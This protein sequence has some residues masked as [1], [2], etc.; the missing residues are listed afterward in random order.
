MC[1]FEFAEKRKTKNMK[2]TKK[3][4]TVSSFSMTIFILNKTKKRK[5]TIVSSESDSSFPFMGYNLEEM[6]IH[7]LEYDSSIATNS[8]KIRAAMPFPKLHQGS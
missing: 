7:F 5:K 2:Q 8:F 3:S 6:L 4:N 1:A